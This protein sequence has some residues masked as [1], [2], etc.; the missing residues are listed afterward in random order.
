MNKTQSIFG[1]FLI[2]ILY[3]FSLLYVSQS[4]QTMKNAPLYD[5]DEAH[6]AENAKQM[7]AY[8]SW[9]VPL[10]GSPQDRIPHLNIAFKDNP[11]LYLFY[12]LERPFLVYLLMVASTSI[13]GSYELFYRLPSFVLGILVFA[14][15]L[16]FTTKV[17]KSKQILAISLGFIALLTS[18][19]LWLSSQYAQLDTG[20]TLF[21]FLSLLL[22]I[23]YC[24]KRRRLLLVISGLSFALAVLSKGQFAVI[25]AFPIFTLLIMRKLSLKDFVLFSL[26]ASVLLIPWV[27]ILSS[28]FSL[29][30]FLRVFIGFPFLQTSLDIHHKA[31][32]FWYARW[33]FESLRPGWTIF[34][35]FLILDALQKNFS[36]RKK[37]LAAYILGGF[38]IFSFQ[39]NKT[40][41]YVLPLIPA[42]A[43]YIY[44]SASEYLKKIN[45][46]LLNI[47]VAVILASLPVFMNVSNK[48]GLIYGAIITLIAIVIL[49]SDF[50][51]RFK[52]G[53]AQKFFLFAVAITLSLGFFYARFP[54]I[55][56][57]HTGIKEVASYYQTIKTRKCL[58]GYGMPLESA[59][60][61]S[62]AGEI[63][64]L[65]KEESES[66][67]F[68]RCNNYLIAPIWVG[69]KEL[70]FVN[71][72]KVLFKNGVIKLVKVEKQSK[73]L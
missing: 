70:L 73:S 41:W 14:I 53:Y 55:V 3:I 16:F 50:F 7:K 40:W 10:T 36:W 31:P 56:P 34:L 6:R 68:A 62:N 4:I 58:W 42:I 8:K 1:I 69:D 63:K 25:F 64:V 24:E 72:K 60:F 46:R 67:F 65:N 29:N 9:F 20:L 71:F 37:V 22:L 17:F 11:D 54:K 39:V 27:L 35:S 26:S 44:E 15:Y 49:R 12:H 30:E 32:F 57:Y 21:L 33:W 47:S 2:I 43:F 52:I 5:F 61:Y 38:L 18:S 45:N 48:E 28:R 19:D 51:S 23:S 66:L 59:L 13:F